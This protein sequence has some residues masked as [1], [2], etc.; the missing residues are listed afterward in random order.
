MKFARRWP[1]IATNFASTT[2]A[3]LS[4]A[5][6]SD[7]VCAAY[8]WR[9]AVL[10]LGT[11]AM[12]PPLYRIVRQ[13]RVNHVGISDRP[14]TTSPLITPRALRRSGC[15][16]VDRADNEVHTFIIP[17]QGGLRKCLRRVVE[18]HTV[19]GSSEA[20]CCIGRNRKSGNCA[21]RYPISWN[22]LHLY[23]VHAV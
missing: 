21:L 7:A 1:Q 6:A 16:G 9:R 10:R 23:W 4:N 22:V 11:N 20:S 15:F 3:R 8:H 12:Q 13:F 5:D 18:C 2:R 17:S 14:S 19:A